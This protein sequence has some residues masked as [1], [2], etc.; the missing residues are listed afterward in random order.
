LTFEAGCEV[1]VLDDLAFCFCSSLRSFIIPSSVET[2]APDCFD[3]H[4]EQIV[5]ESGSKLS[6]KAVSDLRSKCTVICQ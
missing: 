4:L 6:D 1:S 2:I 3:W 5:L